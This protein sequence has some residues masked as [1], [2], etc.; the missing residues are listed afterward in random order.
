MKI[1]EKYMRNVRSMALILLLENKQIGFEI[2]AKKQN[3][4]NL[5]KKFPNPFYL[6]MFLLALLC[7]T[8]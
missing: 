1:Y 7:Q 4:S 5:L 2:L 6:P 8:A 3:E